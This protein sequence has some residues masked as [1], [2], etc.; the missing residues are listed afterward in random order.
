MFCSGAAVVAA[1]V[2]RALDESKDR[3]NTEAIRI[4]FIEKPFNFILMLNQIYL[5]AG[6]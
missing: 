6:Y 3:A 5:V 2:A 4:F 1:S